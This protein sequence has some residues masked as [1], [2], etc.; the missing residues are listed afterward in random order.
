MGNYWVDLVE[1]EEI[2]EAMRQHFSGRSFWN[3]AE[4]D[5]EYDR[6]FQD[7]GFKKNHWRRVRIT[8]SGSGS[9]TGQV[10]AVGFAPEYPQFWNP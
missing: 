8:Y 4:L 3:M 5:A 7:Q 10:G 1:V 6:F 9:P 2:C